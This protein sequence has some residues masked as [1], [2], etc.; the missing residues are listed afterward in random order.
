MW[1]VAPPKSATSATPLPLAGRGWVRGSAGQVQPRTER[2]RANLLPVWEKV[3][4]GSAEGR[5]RGQESVARSAT[6]KRDQPDTRVA[7]RFPKI[8]F[9]S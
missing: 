1:R 3:P 5:M 4:F 9:R 6:Q 8:V 2:Q 7:I